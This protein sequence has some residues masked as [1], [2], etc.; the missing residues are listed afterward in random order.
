MIRHGAVRIDAEIRADPRQLERPPWSALTTTHARFA[1]GDDLARR[2][3]RDVAPMA[4]IRD[5]SP[6]CLQALGALMQPRDVVGLFDAT[7]IAGNKNLTVI[8]HKTV[9]QMVYAGTTAVPV[10]DEPVNLTAADVPEMMRL[11][12]LTKP[13]PFAE[14]TIALGSYI[15]LRID[16]R[17]VAMAG[18]RMRFPGYAEISAVCVLPAYRRR[19]YSALLVRVLMGNMLSRGETPFLHIFSENTAAAALYMQL[20]FLYRRTL[21]VTVLGRSE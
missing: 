3:Q 2:Y 1:L 11:V 18:E 21:T 20:G 19:G 9:E 12:E 14:R 16:G 10:N 4:A 7:P 13:G 15:G 5:T 6:E 8:A 17:L